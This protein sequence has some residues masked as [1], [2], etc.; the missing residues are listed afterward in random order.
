MNTSFIIQYQPQHLHQKSIFS[1][2]Y[3]FNLSSLNEN[4]ESY[5]QDF[6]LDPNILSR[7]L[8]Q[9]ALIHLSLLP[10]NFYSVLVTE[11]Y[12]INSCILIFNNSI[13]GLLKSIKWIAQT[14]QNIIQD[15]T[16]LKQKYK[17]FCS[18]YNQLI[19]NYT[20]LEKIHCTLNNKHQ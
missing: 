2:N 5:M 17:N 13:S 7:K 15:Y 18:I 3:H 11:A 10:T 8:Q 16:K 1:I 20:R 19:D 14:A 6:T 4:I 12:T 9:R